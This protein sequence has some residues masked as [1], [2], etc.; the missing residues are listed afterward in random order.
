MRANR[1]VMLLAL[2]A[3]PLAASADS[4]TA[5]F[6]IPPGMALVMSVERD[7]AMPTL[8]T[9]IARASMSE[10]DRAIAVK[11]A[12]GGYDW[13]QGPRSAVIESGMDGIPRLADVKPGQLKISF[14]SLKPPGHSL[15]IIE[16][17]YADALVYRARITVKGKPT[18]TDVCLVLP[19]KRGYEHWP[20]PIEKIELSQLRRQPWQ[21]GDPVPCV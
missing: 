17:G 3:V 19:G 2:G 5:G 18:A 7:P 20:Y 16:N 10:A 1:I 9:G 21:D 8:L 13:A 4:K 15:L 14:V 11:F 12:G 6:P